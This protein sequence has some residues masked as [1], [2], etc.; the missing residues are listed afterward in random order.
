[1]QRSAGPSAYCFVGLLAALAS[2]LW[3]AMPGGAA[4]RASHCTDLEVR[5]AL[6][7]ETVPR[8][9][10]CDIA[11]VRR[12]WRAFQGNI[13]LNETPDSAA[14]PVGLVTDQQ[15]APGSPTAYPEAGMNVTVSTGPAA[16]PPTVS[17]TLTVKASQPA[18]EGDAL[19]FTIAR[20]P[21]DQPLAVS[22][23]TVSGEGAQPNIDFTPT[24]GKRAFEAN[25]ATLTIPVQIPV[26]AGANGA[27]S[28]ILRVTAIDA[29]G[30]EPAQG[31]GQIFDAA[32]EPAPTFTVTSALA[33]DGLAA[34]FTVTRSAALSPYSLTYRYDAPGTRPMLPLD[35]EPLTFVQGA[36][37]ASASIVFDCA[38]EITFTVSDPAGAAKIVNL[39]Q[40]VLAPSRVEPGCEVKPDP[41]WT[42]PL[43]IGLGV[44]GLLVLGGIVWWLLKRP[45]DSPQSWPQIAPQTTCLVEHGA[46]SCSDATGLPFAIPPLHLSYA[47]DWGD[48]AVCGALQITKLERDDG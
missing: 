37:S 29:P 20:A 8:L 35:P 6:A 22:F 40:A 30:V 39:D 11:F 46:G 31:I 14:T 4:A 28:V 23:A 17:P 33:P 21:A 48:G 26:R 43:V 16:P 18:Q 5:T 38:S 12:A 32:D 42:D 7:G 36:N 9:E 19:V 41:W 27:R 13:P 10:G 24:E 25:V 3:L 45:P 47:T 2:I 34:V 44:A 15:P 1:M